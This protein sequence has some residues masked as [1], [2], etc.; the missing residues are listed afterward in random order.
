MRERKKIDFQNRLGLLKGGLNRLA[1]NP[2]AS[3]EE[4]KNAEAL[5]GQLTTWEIDL[6]RPLKKNSLPKLSGLYDTILNKEPNRGLIEQVEAQLEEKY[7]SQSESYNR[8]ESLEQ[9][10]KALEKTMKVGAKD[11]N[12]P[13]QSAAK[14][15]LRKTRAWRGDINDI[16]TILKSPGYDEKQHIGLLVHDVSNLLQEMD[17][18]LNSKKIRPLADNSRL[19]PAP[20][21]QT[22]QQDTISATQKLKKNDKR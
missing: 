20:A 12:N 9:R 16:K 21:Q 15:L 6:Q 22:E 10:L 5:I 11:H 1:A 3:P 7:R 8:I 4:R 17:K 14:A 2:N 13:H 18:A 19:F